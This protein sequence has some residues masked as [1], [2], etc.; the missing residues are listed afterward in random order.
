MREAGYRL[1]G[2]LGNHRGEAFVSPEAKPDY[3]KKLR[4]R[5]AARGLT[6]NMALIRSRHNIPLADS[7]AQVRQQIENSA[8]LSLKYV[9]SVGVDKP[10]EFDHYYRVFADASA[11]AADRGV[12][13]VL[14]P[15]GGG[16]GAAEEIQRC[17]ERV[18]HPN[19]KIWYDA[20]NIIHY[21]GKDPV[22]ELRPVAQHVT[23]FCAK[24]CAEIRGNVMIQLGAGKVD[25][26]AVF[27][28]LK[29]AKFHGPV[30]VE[31]G[32]GETLAEVTANA[33]ANREFLE[34]I[35]AAI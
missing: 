2:L 13:V 4:D 22:A 25:F 17:L 10:E 27:S 20:G 1:I 12:Q 21:T 6:A 26:P 11:F 9:L 28:E 8:T 29:R 16:S 23:G 35:L 32:A 33:R 3:L 5:I 24:D 15:H 34:R 14:K 30:M 31:C 18:N 7:I 19:F